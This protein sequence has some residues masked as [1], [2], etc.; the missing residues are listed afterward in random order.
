M[1]GRRQELENIVTDPRKAELI[2]GLSDM[3]LEAII[4]LYLSEEQSRL[5]KQRELMI[6]RLIQKW[7]LDDF[8]SQA[9]VQAVQA[10]NAFVAADGFVYAPA[11]LSDEAILDAAKVEQLNPH[12]HDWSM[13]RDL[14]IEIIGA[15]PIEGGVGLLMV[16]NQ[17]RLDRNRYP[18]DSPSVVFSRNE[19][20]LP[21]VVT[22]GHLRRDNSSDKLFVAMESP[23]YNQYGRKD[24]IEVVL[25]EVDK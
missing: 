8:G 13:F 16:H 11:C 19:Y 15:R 25:D 18:G 14:E 4:A 6:L 1:L 12:P 5:L 20:S 7:K 2:S 17:V 23:V 10:M 24:Y 21:G 9:N 3:E 22:F